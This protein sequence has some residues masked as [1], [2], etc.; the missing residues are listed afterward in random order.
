MVFVQKCT[1]S[2]LAIAVAVIF[3]LAALRATIAAS[4]AAV[5]LQGAPVIGLVDKSEPS[6]LYLLI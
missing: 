3:G 6:S 2:S 5:V 4:S 1:P